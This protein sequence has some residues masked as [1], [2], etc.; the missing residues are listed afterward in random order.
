M[1]ANCVHLIC[2]IEKMVKHREC[3]TRQMNDSDK[4][5]VG[6]SIRLPSLVSSQ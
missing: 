4:S 6:L 3:V 5:I 1:K 2:K